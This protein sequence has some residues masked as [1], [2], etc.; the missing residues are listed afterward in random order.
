MT[1]FI[2]LFDT[3]EEPYSAQPRKEYSFN[4]YMIDHDKKVITFSQSKDT[5]TFKFS[6]IFM[7]YHLSDNYIKILITVNFGKK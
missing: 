3:R 4:D 1:G 5:F 6:E 7:D 2:Q